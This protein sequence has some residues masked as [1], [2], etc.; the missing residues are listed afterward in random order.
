MLPLILLVPI[1]KL[2]HYRHFQWQFDTLSLPFASL[3]RGSMTPEELNRTIDFII[4][5]QAR[6]AAAQEQD[7]ADR[8]EFQKYS[9]DLNRQIM[10]LIQT[11]TQLLELQSRRLDEERKWR[12]EFRID[13]QKRHEETLEWLQ[14]IVEKITDR[15]N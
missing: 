10:G 9:K 15:L 8:I 4:Q 12:K 7:R 2:S 3:N 5:S 11:Q 13:A 1:F 14:R 6:L